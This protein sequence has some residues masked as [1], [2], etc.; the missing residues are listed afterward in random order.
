MDNRIAGDGGRSARYDAFRTYYES[1][2]RSELGVFF[3]SYCSATDNDIRF[4]GFDK[5]DLVHM[6][7][8]LIHLDRQKLAWPEKEHLAWFALGI[9][10]ISAADIAVYNFYSEHSQTWEAYTHY[11]KF[12]GWN[13]YASKP[14][15]FFHL[16]AEQDAAAM[17]E[18]E[19]FIAEAGNAFVKE[20]SGDITVL[21][22]LREQDQLFIEDFLIS[23]LNTDVYDNGKSYD[24]QC[25]LH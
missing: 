23:W 15:W 8:I 1:E 24:L 25:F 16:A 9:W 4:M 10:S 21:L 3:Q 11:P 13:Y 22:G 20:L 12:T 6:D 17:S 18:I 5:D 2:F 19:A 7:T 14:N